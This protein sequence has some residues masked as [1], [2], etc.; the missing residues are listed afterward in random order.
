MVA[1]VNL[2]TVTGYTSDEMAKGKS[3]FMVVVSH[4]PE[5]CLEQLDKIS[6]KGAD[7]LNQ[8]EWGCKSGHHTGYALIEAETDAAVKS[9]LPM[10]IQNSAKIIKVNKFSQADLANIHKSMKK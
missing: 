9:M 1:M 8:F 4:T 10:D 2:L 6:A 3:K 5:Q 7:I